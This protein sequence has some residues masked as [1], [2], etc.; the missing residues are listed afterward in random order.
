MIRTIPHQ[1]WQQKP[2]Q[3]PQ[4]RHEEVIH[5]MKEQMSSRKYELSSAS[6]HLTFFAVEKKGGD[7]RVVHDLQPLN[8]VT[9]WDATLPPCVDNMI[10]SFSG[11][12]IYGLFNLKSSYDSRV[13]TTISRDLTSFYVE[14]MGLLRLTHLPQGHTNS[15]AEFQHC[16]QHM[17][18]AMYP[19]KA[20]VFIDNCA[21]K[22][23]KSRYNGNT[24]HGNEQI[25]IFIW[26]Y[27]KVVQELLARVQESRVTISGSKMVLAT[28]HLQL[29]GTEVALDGAHISHEVTAKLAKWPTC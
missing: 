16:T 1:P 17:I 5:I 10:E 6:Y 27:V 9:M 24:I 15:V 7:L 3:L 14:G 20:E 12:A 13:L 25:R 18:G 26:E 23:P 29:L 8:M 11:Q 21:I 22:G 4:S 2:I 19:K 28:P